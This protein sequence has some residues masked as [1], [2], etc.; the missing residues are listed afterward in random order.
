MIEA[1]F[2]TGDLL[3]YVGVLVMILIGSIAIIIG[4]INSIKKK[5]P[6]YFKL[7]VI[8]IGC[9]I[10]QGFMSLYYEL[11]PTPTN[12]D[13]ISANVF[14][15][16]EFSVF[17]TFFLFVL[18]SKLIK[19]GLILLFFAFPMFCIFYW[20]QISSFYTFPYSISIIEAFSISMKHLRNHRSTTWP[21]R[22]HFGSRPACFSILSL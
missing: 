19:L 10:S 7:F 13:A 8:Y 20:F 4:T 14:T 9:S 21:I 5:S 18:Q 16:L 1:L 11:Y 15:L 3:Y 17:N 12:I 6:A 2:K 22:L